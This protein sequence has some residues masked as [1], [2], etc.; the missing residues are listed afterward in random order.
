MT[1][2]TAPAAPGPFGV[3]PVVW[4]VEVESVDTE[5]HIAAVHLSEHAARAGIADLVTGHFTGDWAEAGVRIPDRADYHAARDWIAAVLAAWD[6]VATDTLIVLTSHEPAGIPTPPAVF[7]YSSWRHGGWYVDNISYPGGGCGCVSR[8]FPDRR[9]RIVCD[10]RP[11][12][13]QPTF[14]SRD[15]AALGEWRLIHGL[16]R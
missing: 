10:P 9:W 7:T 5:R 3:T 4:T 2:S 13:Q 6:T 8:N 12:D 15:E 11:F 1:T 16:D 14:A